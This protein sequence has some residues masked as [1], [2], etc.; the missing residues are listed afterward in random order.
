[1][2]HVLLILLLPSISMAH[3]SISDK[4]DVWEAAVE[5][6]V[7]ICKTE[8]GVNPLYPER[9]KFLEFPDEKNFR[10]YMKCLY[11]NMEVMDDTGVIDIA[12]FASQLTHGNVD[13]AEECKGQVREETDLCE[14]AYKLLLCTVHFDS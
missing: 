3:L 13:L 11:E 14:L 7:E 2:K 4:V 5:P 6:Y 10:C 9:M 8:S 12:K 1:M